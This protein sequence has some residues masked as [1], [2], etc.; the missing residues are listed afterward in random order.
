MIEW[1]ARNHVA[2]NLLM[3]TII[4]FGF[5]SLMQK[6]PLEVFPS[7]ELETIEITVPFRGANPEEV[8]QGV[9]VRIEEAIQDLEGIDRITSRSS[10]GVSLVRIE[11]DSDFDVQ[12]LLR[13]VKNRVDAI[14]TLPVDAEKPVTSVAEFHRDV[15]TVAIAAPFSEEEVKILAEQVRDD[16]LRL[17]NVTQ[18]DLDGV[19]PYEIAIE[20]SSEK[21]KHYNLTM[22]Q[23][24]QAVQNSSLDLS[25]GN[26][27]AEGGE[28]RIRSKGQA[29]RKGDFNDIVIA[30]QKDGSILRVR[31]VAT[32]IDGFEETPVSSFFNGKRAAFVDVSRV[33]SQSA[34]EV[35]D[36]VKEYILKKQQML[37][38]EVEL[39]YWRDR[40]SIVKKRL[41]TLFTNAIQGGSLVLLL[42]ALFLRPA[43]AFWVFIGIPVS[44]LGA[45]IFLPHFDVTINVISLFGFILVLGIVVDDAIVTGEN[46]YT[47]LRHAESGLHAAIS[48]TKEVAL[49]VTFGVLT[50]VTAF[51]PLIFVDGPRG[52]IFAQIPLVVIPVLL[53]SLVES[54]FVLPSH[55]KHVKI[56]RER[57]DKGFFS[58]F[59]QAFAT[60]FEQAVLKYYHPLL[61]WALKNR[62]LC[63]EL[64]FG[65]LVITI[66][67]IQSGWMKFTFFPRVQSEIATASLTMPSG[68]PY[69]VTER[70]VNKITDAAFDLKQ[71][72]V[73]PVSGE[74]IILDVMSVTGSV[75]GGS[76][77]SHVGRVRFEIMAPEDR[78]DQ[79][80]SPEIVRAWR[81]KIGVI[82][83]AESLTFRAEIGRSSDPLDIQL[84]GNDFEM[85]RN[86]AD[87]IK[88]KLGTY[89]AIFDINDSMS[90][91]KEEL[92]LELKPEAHALGITR[93]QLIS[94]VRQAFYGF[95]VQRVQRGREDVRVMVRYPLEER[96]AIANLERLEIKTP[97]GS[98]VP[99]VQ[100]ANFVPGKSPTVIYR[101]DRYRTVNVRA[102]VNKDK[103]NMTIITQELTEYLDQLMIQYPGVGYSFEGEQKEQRESFSSLIFGLGFILFAIYCLLAIPFKSYLQPVIV[104]SVI[105]FGVIGAVIGHLIMGADL[106]LLSVFGILAL[107]GIVVNDSLVLVDF[108]NKKI[109]SATGSLQ[110]A[111]SLA[112][113]ARFR[114]VMLTSLTTFFGLMPLLFEKSTQAQF[115]KPMAIS[116]G[117]GIIFATLLTLILVPINYMVI[118][119]IKR[120]F[121]KKG[122]MDQVHKANEVS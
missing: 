39:T 79:I 116:L 36:E 7:V 11:V 38:D 45:F 73:D 63:L 99:L 111:I 25:A 89:P 60:H 95:Q 14:N 109:L 44:F 32:V 98:L 52:K 66:I 120:L 31:D 108:I 62:Y 71:E 88:T 12:K 56:P 104:M 41:Q 53:F 65:F 106:T 74:S 119:D 47:H 4:A 3:L 43:I 51:L 28:V 48:G 42:L 76:V 69:E 2:A 94:Q 58:R 103:A 10:E 46:V 117:F 50:T 15:I 100:L 29:Y 13:D 91:G 67:M 122:L 70:Y 80:T 97:D 114:P 75:G 19:R 18:V 110:E 20:L 57:E 1:F 59:Q 27:K 23:V 90:D 101:A 121:S 8:E 40:S 72:F 33:G 113:A 107:V 16:L 78:H 93:A 49:P 83:G 115:L 84:S 17:P 34:I 61:N 105:P 9:T 81:K 24:A 68:T 6:M 35:A 92:Q 22:A 118:D 54:K 86:A 64:F 96:Q 112:G 87:Q 26:I 21:L 30:T 102:D 55:L 82:P 77:G 37:P 85:L 5:Y